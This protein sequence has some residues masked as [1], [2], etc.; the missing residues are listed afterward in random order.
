MLLRCILMLIKQG[1]G[2][3]ANTHTR[4][5][6]L[7]EHV[8]TTGQVQ[9]CGDVHGYVDELHEVANE[10]HDSEADGDCPADLDVLCEESEEAGGTRRAH[11]THLWRM[12]LRNE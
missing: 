10:A 9:E 12:V 1:K 5:L 7:G 2:I 11:D 4:I 3:L 8:S 6:L